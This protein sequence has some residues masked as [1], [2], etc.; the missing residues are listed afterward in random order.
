MLN[1]ACVAVRHAALFESGQKIALIS[2][3][4]L[5]QYASQILCQTHQG[6]YNLVSN[7][8]GNHLQKLHCRVH[9]LYHFRQN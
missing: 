9:K 8:V 5:C 6:I 7:A 2:N 1:Y 3:G 4:D